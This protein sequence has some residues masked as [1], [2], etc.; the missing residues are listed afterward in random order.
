[1]PD[2][3]STLLAMYQQIIGGSNAREQSALEAECARRVITSGLT[4]AA[5]G[6]FTLPGNVTVGGT[7]TVNNF[8]VTGTFSVPGLL[9][10]GTLAVTGSA[11][12]AG[13]LGVTGLVTASGGL[14]VTGGPLTTSGNCVVAGL[15]QVTGFGQSSIVATGAGI[16]GL[17]VQNASAGTANQAVL[18]LGNDTTANLVILQAMASTYTSSALNLAN[19]GT[20]YCGGAG[21]LSLAAGDAA[22]VLRFFAG[23]T[24]AERMRIMPTGP[25]LVNLTTNGING[26]IALATNGGVTNGLS[27]QNT[28]AGNSIQFCAFFNSAAGVAGL[29]TQTGAATV[30]YNT[31]SDARLKED[32][33]RATD[34]SALREVV[35]HDF[36][37]KADG[38][39]DRGIFA[40]EAHPLY[41][42]AVTVGTDE[43]TED[44]SLAR[45]WMTD[46]SKFVPDLLVGW[47]QHEAELAALRA[48]LGRRV[49]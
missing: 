27:V 1:M 19:G 35:V 8:S 7:L 17:A 32:G 46:Y 6:A 45:P 24:L 33:G 13:T 29:I 4:I 39:R 23:G 5:T 30:A 3:T 21:G 12:V 37:W 9:T 28:N 40:Q 42:R 14:S 44:G 48:L 38:I 11:T 31:S 18:F 26:Q 22:G 20:L 43:T 47:Q 36:T 34:L 49:A 10:V 41:P 25:V 2:V 16:H 15:L